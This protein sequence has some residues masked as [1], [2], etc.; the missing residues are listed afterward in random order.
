M[1]PSAS[2]PGR[3]VGPPR[4]RRDPK[5]IVVPADVV[6]LHP[7]SSGWLDKR[8]IAEY[9]GCSIR[10]INRRM[11]EG[12]PHATIFGKTKFKAD[13]CEAWLEEHGLIERKGEAA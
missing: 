1:P 8:G 7:T 6:D 11:A 4:S 2:S 13:E 10:S 12:M 5:V 3:S 9:F